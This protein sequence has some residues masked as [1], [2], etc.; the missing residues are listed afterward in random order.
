MKRIIT[1][2][3]LAALA[4]SPAAAA[5]P[6]YFHKAGVTR[7]AFVADF[8]EC[9]GLAR[10]VREHAQPYVYSP[11]LYTTLAAAFFAGLTSGREQRY[12]ADNVLRTCMAD[13]GYRRVQ[14]TKA[15]TKELKGL[16]ER[17]RIDR[18]FALAA[19]PEPQGG[20]LPR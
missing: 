10:G 15:V 6:I 9:A 12:M 17:E 19:E 14:A 4:A 16:A 13:K 7:E 3:I 18:L 2:A 1:G 5:D 20:I 8:D 11:N